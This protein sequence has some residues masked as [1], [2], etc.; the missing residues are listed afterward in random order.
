LPLLDKR[1]PAFRSLATR[2][3]LF[4]ENRTESLRITADGLRIWLPKRVT[5]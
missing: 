2:V 3:A 1:A 4:Q 5:G